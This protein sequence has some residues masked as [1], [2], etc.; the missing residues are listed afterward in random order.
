MC[1]IHGY[2]GAILSLKLYVIG[3]KFMLVFVSLITKYF[4][5]GRV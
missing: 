5:R 1:G 4:K 3:R 2:F